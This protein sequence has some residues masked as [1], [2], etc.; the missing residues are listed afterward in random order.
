MKKKSK[1]NGATYFGNNAPANPMDL[2]REDGVKEVLWEGCPVDD[3]DGMLLG[4]LG[5]LAHYR[6][7]NCGYD[8]H[9]EIKK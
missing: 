6:C 8:F 2:E 9:I 7:R 3:G 4:V 5:N 1:N